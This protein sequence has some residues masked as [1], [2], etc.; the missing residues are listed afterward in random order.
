MGAIGN[1]W[2]TI[3]Q[4]L[5]S[6]A[7]KH[8]EKAHFLHFFYTQI[9][10][11]PSFVNKQ[12]AS[13]RYFRQNLSDFSHTYIK[14]QQ[15]KHPSRLDKELRCKQVSIGWHFPSEV[16]DDFYG[17]FC[18]CCER[19]ETPFSVR[20]FF[21]KLIDRAYPLPLQTYLGYL[22]QG[23][24]S[25]WNVTCSYI[26][27]LVDT[28]APHVLFHPLP[29]GQSDLIKDA[30]WSD[31]Y[32][33]LRSK[34][35]QKESPLIFSSGTDFR[36]Y[37]IQICHFRLQNNRV[38]YATSQQE[39]SL[40]QYPSLELEPEDETTNEDSPEWLTDV[41]IHNPYEVAYAVSIILQDVH[42]PLYPLLTQGIE[43]KVDILIRKAVNGQG[44]NQIVEEKYGLYPEASCFSKTVVKTRKEY[45]RIRKTLQERFIQI[46]KNGKC[47][48]A[49]TCQIIK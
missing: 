37:L 9:I 27:E 10:D 8:V 31:T 16:F 36:N 18:S 42:H 23:L 39:E 1:L 35:Q 19:F 21:Q 6:Y 3:D 49:A 12:K 22:K 29:D 34:L 20:L 33:I 40:E 13:N 44:Y 30:V 15:R 38:K 28:V 25:F 5:S 26:K 43:D 11:Y 17:C 41:D 48:T 4:A 32:E 46:K 7:E 2:R 47:H 24:S 14:A 45:E